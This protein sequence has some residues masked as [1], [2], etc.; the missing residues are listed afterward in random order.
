MLG[1]RGGI[2]VHGDACRDDHGGVVAEVEIAGD[3]EDDGKGQKQEEECDPTAFEA[4]SAAGKPE[5]SHGVALDDGRMAVY[6]VT[7]SPKSSARLAFQPKLIPQ[8]SH[9]A[10][11]RR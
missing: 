1:A 5:G 6:A 8:L 3:A 9:K 4:E 2:K 10:R 7:A 11:V